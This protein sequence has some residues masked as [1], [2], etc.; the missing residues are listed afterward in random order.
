MQCQQRLRK[1]INPVD[2]RLLIGGI[3]SAANQRIDVFNPARPDELVSTIARARPPWW[4]R[5]SSGES[6]ATGMGGQE[7]HGTRGSSAVSDR[8]VDDIDERVVLLSAKTA[9]HRPNRASLR[10]YRC[11]NALR[12]RWRN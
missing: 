6:R 1:I 8:L 9:R 2:A 4:R 12:W 5:D 10:T 3:G 11:A 7:L